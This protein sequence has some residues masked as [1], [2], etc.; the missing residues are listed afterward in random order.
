MKIQAAVITGDINGSSYLSVQSISHL[1]SII[2]ACFDD[3]SEKLPRVHAGGFSSFMGD[4]WQ[5]V[6]AEPQLAVRAT[7]LFRASLLKYSDEKLGKKLHSS[8]A[9]GFGSINS[10]PD[11]KS[12]ANSGEAF[13][14]SGKRLTKLRRRMPGMGVSGLGETNQYIDS[15]LALF[16]AIIRRW[17]APQAAAMSYALSGNF[18]QQEIAAV[19]E[20]P[21]SQ[22]A[23]NK[24][25][26]VAGWP[27]IKPAL[28]LI[29]TTLS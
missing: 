24:H 17:T 11:H 9:I 7:L 20:S 26:R 27:A 28:D 10:H 23:V 29:E 21:I 4:S 6:A 22:Q 15:Q 25:L 13:I 19:F 14:L 18:S 2:T 1:E 12:P 3:L 5:F 16:D 8:A